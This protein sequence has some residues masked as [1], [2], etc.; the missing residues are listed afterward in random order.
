[1]VSDVL[2]AVGA[3]KLTFV[4]AERI[5]K[6]DEGGASRPGLVPGTRGIA[7][8][9]NASREAPPTLY[10]LSNIAFPLRWVDRKGHWTREELEKIE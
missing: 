3:R 9:A 8:P 4:Y 2:L 5:P 7:P 10:T 6:L 1:M